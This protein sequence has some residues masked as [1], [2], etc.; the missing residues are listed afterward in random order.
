[1]AV[2]GA[3]QKPGTYD[4]ANDG[5]SL[6]D[7]IG[8]AGGLSPGASQTILFSPVAGRQVNYGD[9]A[10]SMPD[11]PAPDV[12]TVN[13][14][15]ASAD[16]SSPTITKVSGGTRA[17]R[18]IVLDID[19]AQQQ[20]CLGLPARPGDLVIVPAAGQVMV[21]GWVQNPGAFAITPRMTLLGAVSAAG[22][23]LFSWNAELLR[24]DPSGGKTITE[25]SLTK[26]RSGQETDPPVQS[27]DVVMVEKSVVG[28]VPYTLY[29]LATRFGTGLGFALPVF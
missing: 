22:G 11:R 18:S 4:M 2:M 19:M 13:E 16:P 24:P 17:Q 15:Y 27:G 6:M 3:V 1:V 20:A 10:G 26:L 12:G 28:A 21:G 5:D 23:P 9:A 14:A 7:M 25:Y 29:F 8:L